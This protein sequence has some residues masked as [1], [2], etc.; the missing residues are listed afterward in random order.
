MDNSFVLQ[1]SLPLAPS[2]E[3]FTC[4]PHNSL[5]CLLRFHCWLFFLSMLAFSLAV[6]SPLRVLL[7]RWSHLVP[8]YYII[9]NTL[10]IPK[11]HT[12]YIVSI[13]HILIFVF[14]FQAPTRA[15]S[16]LLLIS[17]YCLFKISLGMSN[18]PLTVMDTHTNFFISIFNKFFN[19]F[20]PSPVTPS[21]LLAPPFTVFQT[22]H[23]SATFDYL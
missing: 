22:N 12:Y 15:L 18:R 10:I 9:T 5:V 17:Y 23:Q 13:F 21:Q 4:F 20:E 1:Y 2:E 7:P 14:Y 8:W 11:L 19:K 3:R 6:L 16:L